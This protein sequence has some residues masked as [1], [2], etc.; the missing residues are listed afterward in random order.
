MTVVQNLPMYGLIH[1][2][3]VCIQSLKLII[4]VVL[5]QDTHTHQCVYVCLFY[6]SIIVDEI[7]E[8]LPA[9]HV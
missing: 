1:H 9:S 2:F 7:N 5:L 3:P 8:L 6:V 4:Q